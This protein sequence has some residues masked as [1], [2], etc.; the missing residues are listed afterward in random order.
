MD[1]QDAIDEVTQLQTEWNPKAAQ[2]NL[3][4]DN[5]LPNPSVLA[6]TRLRRA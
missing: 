2:T 6:A 5:F 4:R 1:T 3:D